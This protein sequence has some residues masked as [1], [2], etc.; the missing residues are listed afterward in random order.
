MKRLNSSTIP[1][2]WVA[3]LPVSFHDIYRVSSNSSF[4]R[5]SL[6][7]FN[8]VISVHYIYSFINSSH[9]E[10]FIWKAS[11]K[12]RVRRLGCNKSICLI[13]L[14]Q[15]WVVHS[16]ATCTYLDMHRKRFRNHRCRICTQ[17]RSALFVVTSVVFCCNT[18]NQLLVVQVQNKIGCNILPRPQ[19]SEWT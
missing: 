7:D 5:M 18:C 6:T 3:C 14:R 15:F 1:R 2:E 19:C 11:T 16:S 10:K 9:K 13:T 12:S 17:L 8:H 4:L